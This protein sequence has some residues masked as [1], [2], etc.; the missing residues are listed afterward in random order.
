MGNY[1]STIESLMVL[2]RAGRQEYINFHL[3]NDCSRDWAECGYAVTSICKM[4]YFQVVFIF[5]FQGLFPVL[6]EGTFA[7]NTAL[8]HV[9]SILVPSEFP[10]LSVFLPVPRLPE[11]GP[12]SALNQLRLLKDLSPHY[13]KLL[14]KNSEA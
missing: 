4:L 5:N 14:F 7:K 3:V 11:L 2:L 12:S 9:S 8:N 6:E 13:Y 1:V 10:H